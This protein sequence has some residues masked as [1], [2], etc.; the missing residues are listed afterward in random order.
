MFVRSGEAGP[1]RPH[2]V[3][4]HSDAN[5]TSGVAR[6]FRRYGWM[7]ARAADGPSARRLAAS[8]SADLVVL[9]A[10]LPEESGWLTCAKMSLDSARPAIVLVADEADCEGA[11]ADFAGASRLVTR[12]QGCEPL[13]EEA[14]IAMPVS[15]VV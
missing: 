3:I 4:A 2:V 13:L 5:Y 12:D 15:Q 14:G 8:L 7:V 10:N 9:Q 6:T 1:R 11:F